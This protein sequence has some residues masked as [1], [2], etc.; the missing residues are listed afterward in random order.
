MEAEILQNMA[1]FFNPSAW[2]YGMRIFLNI[3][4]VVVAFAAIAGILFLVSA[5]I[6]TESGEGTST[7]QTAH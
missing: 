6:G 3:A 5:P 1:G 4:S 7:S 2:R